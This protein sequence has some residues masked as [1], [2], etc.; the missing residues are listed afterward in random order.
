MPITI[1]Y[2][3]GKCNPLFICDYCQQ[4]IKDATVEGNYI[5]NLD[6]EES[7]IYFTH[8]KCC[9]SFEQKYKAINWG[10]ENL[11]LLLVYLARNSKV[12]FKKSE[13]QC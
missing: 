2:N 1:F 4:E 5:W 13:Q 6:A 10:A 8:K 12:N 9:H 11:D 7:P 3:K